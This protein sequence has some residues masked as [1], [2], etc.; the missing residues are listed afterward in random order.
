MEWFTALLAKILLSNSMYRV[1]F[2]FGVSWKKV[3]R[4]GLLFVLFLLL[5]VRILAHGFLSVL[6]S[7]YHCEKIYKMK[8]VK[9]T[10]RSSVSCALRV[11][12]S[13]KREPQLGQTLVG[14]H[15]HRISH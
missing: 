9:S 13:R 7:T 3:T 2:N 15:Q 1:C 8:Y 6:A 11:N 10:Y 12:M 14:K 4:E 5:F